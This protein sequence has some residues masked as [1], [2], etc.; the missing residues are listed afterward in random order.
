[1]VHYVSSFRSRGRQDGEPS[2]IF[3]HVCSNHPTQGSVRFVVVSGI[4]VS[5][6]G[7][8]P[9][10]SIL[11]SSDNERH[12]RLGNKETPA[13]SKRLHYTTPTNRLSALEVQKGIFNFSAS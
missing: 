8:A 5:F 10:A 11:T 9:V 6:H 13:I 12:V 7:P 2:P 3:R 4:Q 1:Q